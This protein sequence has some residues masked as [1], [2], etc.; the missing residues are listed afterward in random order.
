MTTDTKSKRET[1][2]E[3]INVG[4]LMEP[5]Q[6]MT[7]SEIVSKLQS[8]GVDVSER[9][10][11]YW[12][13]IG[14]LPHPVREWHEGAV[15]AIY[16][17]FTADAVRYVRHRQG[18]GWAL[19]KI[20]LEMPDWF[21]NAAMLPHVA[22][23]NRIHKL[24]QDLLDAAELIERTE[25]EPVAGIEMNLIRAEDGTLNKIELNVLSPSGRH[26][27]GY[28]EELTPRR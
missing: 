6:L 25:G 1:W 22:V 27:M 14:V 9:T 28:S 2:R 5:K 8:E 23:E 21:R 24:K 18:A 4:R 16:P 20:A 10:L 19:E 11:G 26:I 17:A 15:R 13:K 12:E 7:R 3:W